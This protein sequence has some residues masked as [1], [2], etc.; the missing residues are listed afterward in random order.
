MKTQA[1]CCTVSWKEILISKGLVVLSFRE[2]IASEGKKKAPRAPSSHVSLDILIGNGSLKLLWKHRM[3][4]M[5]N[6]PKEIQENRKKQWS[7]LKRA[8]E[9]GK[10]AYFRYNN[11]PEM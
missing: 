7:R 10:T 11:P 6:L 5:L 8:R 3:R 2:V 9:E 1:K 4:L